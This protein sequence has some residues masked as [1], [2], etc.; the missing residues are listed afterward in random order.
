MERTTQNAAMASNTHWSG[1]AADDESIQ[2][3]IYEMLKHLKFSVQAATP[4]VKDRFD[5]PIMMALTTDKDA[6]D[7]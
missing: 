2:H 4:I 1:F 3:G 7:I 6:G 5:D